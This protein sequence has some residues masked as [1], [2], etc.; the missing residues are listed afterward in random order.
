[1]ETLIPYFIWAAIILG[2]LGLL[3]MGIFSLRG[4]AHGKV[5]PL[6][7]V[8]IGLPIA[9]FAILGFTMESWAVAGIYTFLV[10][11]VV[12]CLALFLSGMRNFFM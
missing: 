12:A 4:V 5:E 8:I 11:F 7:A 6:S 9:L 3:M 2:G 10:M 1:M